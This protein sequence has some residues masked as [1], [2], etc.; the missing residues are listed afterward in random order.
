M[1]IDSNFRGLA[2]GAQ[3]RFRS[4]N[5]GATLGNSLAA[6]IYLDSNYR[7]MGAR[8]AL[9]WAMALSN[10]RLRMVSV[11]RGN[12]GYA[13]DRTD[14]IMARLAPC[15]ASGAGTIRIEGGTN[16]IG[17]LYPTAGTCAATAAA[18][19]LAMCRAANAAG[20]QVILE[21]P[22][23]SASWTAAQIGYLY[24][25]HQRLLEGA[26]KL[27]RVFCH[28]ASP[29]V[30]NPVNSTSALAWKLNHNYDQTHTQGLGAYYWGKSLG[31]LI[32]QI[33]PPYPIPSHISLTDA[34]YGASIVNGLFATQSGGTNNIGAALTAGAVPGGWTLNR[35][36]SCTVAISYGADDGAA[37]DPA[38]GSKCIL[39]ITFTAAGE[40]LYLVQDLATANWNAGDAYDFGC[41]MRV[42]SGMSA[43]SA[44]RL[45]V[46]CSLDGV[47]VGF[48]SLIEG[49]VSEY[50]PDEAYAVN[51]LIA[52]MPIQAGTTKNYLS[53]R[54]EIVARTA[55]TV[56][57]E[58]SRFAMRKRIAA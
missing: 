57:V 52:G 51:H 35:S 2:A 38:I 34:Q 43:V 37:L 23:G 44:A 26:A 31:A 47:S 24:E 50:G 49:G 33:V 14:Q 27:P 18:N 28:D 39:T 22:V 9:A 48:Y 45:R 4:P 42:T 41:R 58:V 17:A 21:L 3:L 7:N 1:S 8:S 16:D 20:A 12:F 53:P 46:D 10:Q 15:L 32:S 55:G 5:L 19:L 54:G 36:G 25:L 11:N 29:F 13:G 30:L 40:R 56:V 6:D